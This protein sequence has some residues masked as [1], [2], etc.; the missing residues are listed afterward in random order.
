MIM[1]IHV[2]YLYFTSINNV[3]GRNV[4][5]EEEEFDTMENEIQ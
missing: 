3:L 5:I 2:G 4:K 1:Q